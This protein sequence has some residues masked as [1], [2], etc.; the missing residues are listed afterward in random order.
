MSALPSANRAIKQQGA[1]LVVALLIAAIVAIIAT[2]VGNNYLLSYKRSVNTILGDQAILYLISAETIA[3]QVLLADQPVTQQS[4]SGSGGGSSNVQTYVDHYGEDWAKAYPPVPIGA[5]Q[6]LPDPILDL[7]GRFNINALLAGVTTSGNKK[8]PPQA[9]GAP[10]PIQQAFIRLLQTFEEPQISEAQARELTEAV[11]DWLDADDNPKGFGGAES[12]YYLEQTPAYRAANTAMHDVSELRLIKGMTEAL[13]TVLRPHV[14]A[15]P[16]EAGALIKAKVNVNTASDNVLRAM[17]YRAGL[18]YQPLDASSVAV[19]RE[20]FPAETGFVD[21]AAFAADSSWNGAK[22]DA[23]LLSVESSY[24]LFSSRVELG[25]LSLP[26]T[27]VMEREL[28]QGNEDG[29]IYII[30]RTIGAL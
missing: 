12:S 27:S 24:F 5:G 19:F 2:R 18:E 1:A 9:A 3:S 26:M 25:E 17:G 16:Q 21:T 11:I 28:P 29:N 23:S 13:Y 7:Q 14:V 15:L 8:Q 20:N 6:V 30:S 4:S 22:F 10:T